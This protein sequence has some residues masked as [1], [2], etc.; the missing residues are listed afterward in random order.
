HTG[1]SPTPFERALAQQ[2]D[3]GAS[4][5]RQ[6]GTRLAEATRLKDFTDLK[7]EEIVALTV[8][9]KVDRYREAARQLLGAN[10][11][12]IPRF[13]LK[14]PDEVAAAAAFREQPIDQGLLRHSA[15]PMIVEE[16]LQ[17]AACVRDRL[18]TLDTVAT[19][20]DAFANP[21]TA[22]RPLQLPF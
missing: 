9:Q 19:M 5:F 22:L 1:E 4:A 13:M 3:L 2:L 21:F 17:G 14:N 10:F 18:H 12:L 8:A 20:S 7:A 16:W 6:A 15:N 11:N